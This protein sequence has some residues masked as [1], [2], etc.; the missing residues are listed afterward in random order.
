MSPKRKETTEEERKIIINLRKSN[1]SLRKIGEIVKRPYST[2]KKIID[3][4]NKTKKIAND[5]RCGRPQ[6]LSDAEKRYIVREIKKNP[7]LPATE[8]TR[9]INNNFNKS[10]CPNTV[11]KVLHEGGYS[12]RVPRKKPYISKVNKA[13]RLKYAEEHRNKSNDFWNRVVFTDESK[14]NIYGNDGRC[15]VWRKPN[16][17][18]KEKNLC[19][20]FKHGGGSVLVW[21]CMSAA[22]VGNLQIIDGIMDHKKYID[23]LK[24]HLQPSVQKM[25]IA[26]NFIF[27]QDNDP[28][29]TAHNTKLWLVYNT[30]KWM[31]TPPQ[32]PDIN[33]IENLWDH[34]DRKV[35]EREIRNKTELAIALQEEWEKIPP[36]VTQN[37]VDSIPR[38]LEAIIKNKG[39]H[40][41]Y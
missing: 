41:K 30:P 21:G 31:E 15:R 34:L 13:K 4:Y 24:T 8:I 26:E 6:A 38:R 20:T 14:F 18:F 5:P 11:R 40:T 2:I 10:I 28:K 3:K 22:G 39:S 29:H 7:K 9:T 36:Q 33:P 17:E 32:S 25:G 27:T 12:S 19:P 16:E 37:L 35:R 1:N 23:I